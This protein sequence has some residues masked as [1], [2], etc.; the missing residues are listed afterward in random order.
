MIFHGW[1]LYFLLNFLSISPSGG[2]ALIQ[3]RGTPAFD[4]VFIKVAIVTQYITHVDCNKPFFPIMHYFFVLFLWG[5][6]N[7]I[8][9]NEPNK[10]F[11]VAE[12]S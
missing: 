6:K 3:Q 7:K 2:H 11:T 10:S 12:I 9:K 4:S 5:K 1:L 8:Q